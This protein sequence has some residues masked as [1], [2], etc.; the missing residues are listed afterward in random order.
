[1]ARPV[2]RRGETRERILA[3]ALDLFVEHGA[4]GTSLQM[5]A[6]ALGVTKA[7]VYHQF[8]TKEEILLA[9]VRPSLDQLM[10]AVVVAQAA[11]DPVRRRDLAVEGLV[12]AVLD[13]H[14]VLLVLQGDPGATEMLNNHPEIE[15]TA[16]QLNLL[17]LGPEPGIARIVAVA[18]I[19][20]GVMDLGRKADRV[21]ADRQV[22]RRELLAAARRLLDVPA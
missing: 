8:R 1:M 11:E 16:G 21:G 12:D 17:L 5:I 3:V 20:G 13:H 7:A 18:M 9:V 10:A 4:R 2:G 22:L 14:R 6:D 19:F 15:A